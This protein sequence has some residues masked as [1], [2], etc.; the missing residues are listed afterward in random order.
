MTTTLSPQRTGMPEPP[1][2]EDEPQ[3]DLR[4]WTPDEYHRMIEMD[5][6]NGDRVELLSDGIWQVHAS[7]YYRWTREQYHRLIEVGFFDDGRVELLEGLIWN[8]AGQLTP[9]A[10][11]VRKTVLAMQ[12]IF[13][14]GYLVSSQLPVGIN[15]WSEPEPDVSVVPGVPDDYADHHPTPE[16]IL[17]LVEVSDASLNKDRK[18]KAQ[19]YARASVTD[20]WIVNLVHRQLEVHRQ[21][22]PD[23]VY[24]SI[25]T[26]APTDA[27]ELLAAPG[28]TVSVADLLPP[29]KQL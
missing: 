26:Y 13:E 9:H 15:L 8:M 16:E 17:L 25:Q 2:P 23:G 18:R 19:A 12:D 29:S 5:L 20:Y 1:R 28:Q 27:V 11:S 21:P 24:L 3:D 4:R 22:T 10:T 7:D 6:F 14:V